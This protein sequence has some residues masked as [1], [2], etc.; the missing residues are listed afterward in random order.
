[1]KYSKFYLIGYSVLMGITVLAQ[2][3]PNATTDKSEI[4][5]GEQFQLRLT[6]SFSIQKFNTNAF[7]IPDSIKH[8]EIIDRGSIDSVVSNGV[9]NLSQT[10]ILTSFDS[11]TWALPPIALL[12]KKIPAKKSVFSDSIKIKVGYDSTKLTQINDIKPIIDTEVNTTW[13][14]WTLG[15]VTLFSL[16]GLYFLLRKTKFKKVKKP[17]SEIP[18]IQL[19]PYDEAITFLARLKQR[20]VAN[21][22]DAKLLYSDL[23][24]IFKQYLLK[25]NKVNT[26][27]DTS[28]EVLLK[29]DEEFITPNEL[30]ALTETFNLCDMV[31]FATYFPGKEET[32]AAINEIEAIINTLNKQKRV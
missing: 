10:I 20:N 25:A 23:T 24:N 26:F 8:F 19:T 14:Y 21:R 4:L 5:I 6:A 27:K 12:T 16:V 29:L 2:P 30:S 7:I 22:E 32:S 18:G 13:M 11:G 17:A 3:K 31:K 28:S 15:F 9:K 1:M